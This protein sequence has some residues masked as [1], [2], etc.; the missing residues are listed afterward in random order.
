MLKFKFGKFEMLQQFRWSL[1]L[2][3]NAVHFSLLT[4]SQL[5]SGTS[6]A[7]DTLRKKSTTTPIA[8]AAGTSATDQQQH[9][10]LSQPG[11]SHDAQATVSSASPNLQTSNILSALAP[12]PRTV[13]SAT[14]PVN[15]TQ[16]NTSLQDRIHS[17]C[18]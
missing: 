10:D 14:P 4:S 7:E 16:W 18:L 13:N 11:F 12:F 3:L 8:A 2:S 1:D 5:V 6:M 9:Q 15:N 17:L